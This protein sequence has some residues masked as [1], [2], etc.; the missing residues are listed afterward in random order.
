MTVVSVCESKTDICSVH[1]D[2]YSR[3]RSSLGLVI[4]TLL[5]HG[6]WSYDGL[7]DAVIGKGTLTGQGQGSS[8]GNEEGGG[9]SHLVVGCRRC[10]LVK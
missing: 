5:A 2:D 10:G 6:V 7:L 3:S 9:E 8:N 1:R 4:T